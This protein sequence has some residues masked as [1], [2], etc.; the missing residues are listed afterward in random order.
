M[1]YV[2]NIA[3][4]IGLVGAINGLLI[5]LS[6]RNSPIGRFYEGLWYQTILGMKARPNVFDPF[7][8]APQFFAYRV[9]DLSDVTSDFQIIQ[10]G[11]AP[12]A[13]L[14]SSISSYNDHVPLGVIV[15]APTLEDARYRS[16]LMNEAILNARVESKVTVPNERI[17]SSG[18]TNFGRAETLEQFCTQYFTFDPEE[19]CFKGQ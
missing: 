19:L 18:G 17:V 1:G 4:L 6:D 15:F 8:T 7:A 9:D 12:R 5:I 2:K 13:Y 11:I 14:A 10:S 16:A 3:A